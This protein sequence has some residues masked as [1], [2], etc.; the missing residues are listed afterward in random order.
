MRVDPQCPVA[1]SSLSEGEC[2]KTQN[3]PLRQPQITL[4]LVKEEQIFL[5]K[6]LQL[7]CGRYNIHYYCNHFG[8]DNNYSGS[9]IALSRR[10]HKESTDENEVNG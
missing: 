10:F 9:Y 2:L 6:V 4:L 3:L 1:I 5:L 8:C 7:F